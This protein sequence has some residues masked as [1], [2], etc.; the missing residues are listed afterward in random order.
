[1]GY[2]LINPYSVYIVSFGGALF[3]YSL[4]WS[5]YYPSLQWP[6]MV[7][8]VA[9]FGVCFFLARILYRNF[10]EIPVASPK[11]SLRQVIAVTVFLYA[12]W[13]WEFIHAGG[14]PLFLVLLG[15]PFNYRIFGVPSLHVF[16]VTFCSFYTA[17]LFHAFLSSRDKKILLFCLINLFSSVLILNRGML[18]TNLST[19]FFI[20]CLSQSSPKNLITQRNIIFSIVFVLVLFFLFGA[21]GTLRVSREIKRLYDRSLVY[22]VGNATTSFKQSII[23]SEFFWGYTY[24]ASPLAN[25]QH[26]IT[27]ANPDINVVN[28]FLLIN[29]EFIPDALSKRI[30]SKLNLPK[31]DNHQIA[32]NLNASTVFS[33]SFT[34]WGWAG[35]ILM[36]GMLMCI[37]LLLRSI[38]LVS[39]PWLITFLALLN[40]LYLFLI[41]DNMLAFT[42]FSFQLVYPILFSA[43]SKFSAPGRN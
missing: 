38:G 9:S 33:G 34:Y 13:G 26:N 42:G 29:N 6:L 7:F 25:L 11:P 18:L 23:P 24:I 32:E 35:I 2:R 27:F 12:L 1:M 21:M 10:R 28:F 19:I 5:E 36:L 39:G 30:N 37:P 40:T 15:K 8:F 14:V 22:E 31:R 41:F 43:V 3:F 20:Y 4:R 17:Y 16:A